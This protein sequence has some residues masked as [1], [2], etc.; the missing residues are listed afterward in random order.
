MNG[1]LVIDKP[2]GMTS[3]DVVARV[4]RLLGERRIGHAGTLDPSATG[5][6]LLGLGRATRLLRF[7]EAER[8]EYRAEVLFGVE[9]TTQDADGDIVSSRDATALTTAEI[10]AALG[11]FR[12][13]IRQVPPMVSAIKVGG[14]RLYRKARRGETVE[15]EARTVTIDALELLAFDPPVATLRIE[16]SKGT[17]IR[18]IA[19]DL[20]AAV[21]TGAHLAALRRTR[22]GPFSESSAVALEDATENAILEM[23]EAIRGYPR[24]TVDAEDA[25]AV[26]HGKVLPPAGIEGTYAIWGPEGL[27]AMARDD[28]DGTRSLCVVGELPA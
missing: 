26:V 23:S 8:K 1:I 19:A 27:V 12:G 7:I 2:S 6:L 17:Y 15:R 24:R 20:G 13:E 3:H 9:T 5:V 16:C 11:A 25:R 14:E 4:R 10:K 21:G 18:S 22:I 28:Q